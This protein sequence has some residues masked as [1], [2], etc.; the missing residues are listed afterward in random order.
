MGYAYISRNER[1]SNNYRRVEALYR[2]GSSFDEI[3]VAYGLAKDDVLDITQKIFALDE[4][5]KRTN[6]FMRNA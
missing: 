4:K 6:R 3:S 1:L 2:S 5:K